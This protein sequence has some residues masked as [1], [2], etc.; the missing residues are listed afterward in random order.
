[1]WSAV[2]GE[3][4]EMHQMGVHG[5]VEVAGEAPQFD[6]AQGGFGQ[7]LGRV[8]RLP[9]DGPYAHAVDG[10]LAEIELPHGRHLP[11]VQMLWC[12][13]P[14]CD[15]ALVAL[16]TDYVEPHHPSGVSGAQGVVQGHLRTARIPGEADDRVEALRG[17][18]SQCVVPDRR[19]QEPMP[20]TDLGE[21]CCPPRWGSQ[22][23][24]V[25][26]S[27]GSIEYPKTI[28]CVG[29]LH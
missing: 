27:V 5:M 9:V 8:E 18:H 10:G 2:T 3:D 16:G 15:G 20:A 19:L 26:T 17:R 7:I 4:L 29:D 22:G 12:G 28:E 11:A 25:A 14:L 6:R 23:E 21:C 13:Q 1:G 24:S